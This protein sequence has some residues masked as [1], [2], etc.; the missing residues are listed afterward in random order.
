MENSQSSK[1]VLVC[2]N[3]TCRRQG[4]AKVLAAFQRLADA[5]IEIIASGCLGH[6]GSGPMVLVL[7]EKVWYSRV[8]AEEVAVAIEQH[9]QEGK[10]IEEMLY[11]K[12]RRDC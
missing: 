4:A 3:R 8:C 9:L 12:K 10:P 2:Q 5:E 11:K 7:P 6:C 1:R